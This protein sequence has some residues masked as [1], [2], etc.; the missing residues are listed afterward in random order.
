MVFAVDNGE[1]HNCPYC[2]GRKT[3]RPAV[4]DQLFFL[5]DMFA[6][7]IATCTADEGFRQSEFLVRFHGMATDQQMTISFERDEFVKTPLKPLPNWI[8][9]LSIE[10]MGALESACIYQ[11]M[12]TL[13]DGIEFRPRTLWSIISVVWQRRL[14][15]TADEIWAVAL[16][17]GANPT[18]GEQFRTLLDFGIQ[19]QIALNGRKA[20]ARK[21]CAPFSVGNYYTSGSLENR[22]RIGLPTWGYA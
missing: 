15:I 8:C 9:P 19:T 11:I 12:D 16:A 2:M 10:D 18:W 21:R 17:H 14:P 22:K 7:G 1:D 20:I 13:Q 3:A 6:G 5:R 4:G